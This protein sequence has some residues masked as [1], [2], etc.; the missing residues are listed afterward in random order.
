MENARTQ[1]IVRASWIGIF[2]NGL[3]AVL[4]IV[5]G[6]AGNSMAVLSDG[7]DSSTDIVTSAITLFTGKIIS[8]PPDIEHPYGHAR[9]ETI[10]T[11]L[12]SFVIFFA[13]AQLALSTIHRLIERQ[14]IEF[15]SPVTVYVT[16]FS[17]A[18]KAF[19]ALYK[20]RVGRKIGSAMLIADAKNMRND[21]VISSAVLV[22]LIFTFVFRLPVFD[23]VTAL[24]VSAWIM[25][26][27]FGIF[28]ETNAELMEGHEDHELYRKIFLAVE[29]VPEAFHPHRTRVRKIGSMYIVDLDIEVDERLTVGDAHIIAQKIEEIIAARIENVYDVLVHVEPIGNIEQRERYGVSRRKLDRMDGELPT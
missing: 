5:I 26:V 9:A 20:F 27:A 6:F 1:Q 29:E 11:K 15:P 10:A 17:I 24:L 16:L 19:L 25:R 2:G 8:K 22:G 7:I 21:I 3:L 28:I 14:S 23:P 12:L 13:G 18:A 4:K